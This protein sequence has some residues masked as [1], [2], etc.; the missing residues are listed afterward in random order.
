MKKFKPAELVFGSGIIAIYIFL[1]LPIVVVFLA[2]ISETSYLTFPPKQITLKW[3]AKAF[4]EQKYLSSFRYSLLVA[5]FTVLFS[6]I[7]G[8]MGN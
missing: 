5:S 6:T 3:Y 4:S 2:S 7:I 8:T 1:L